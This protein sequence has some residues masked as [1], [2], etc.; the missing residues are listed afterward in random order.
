MPDREADPAHRRDRPAGPGK[1]TRRSRTDDQHLASSCDRGAAGST[2]SRRLNR[3]RADGAPDAEHP[4][5]HA[6][7]NR[8]NASPANDHRDTR[9]ERG[10]RVD[11]DAV[12]AL[13]Q[14]PA[15]VVGRRL[16]AEAE[17]RQP[18][19]AS[20]AP[21]APMVA[22]TTSGSAMLGRTC[23]TSSRNRPTPA[24]RAAATKSRSAIAGDQRLRQP[25]ERRRP[26]EPD[27]QHRALRA[28]PEDHREEER[29]Q[30]PGERDRDVHDRRRQPARA[31]PSSSRRGAEQQSGEDA[32]RGRQQGQRDRR[33]GSRPARGRRCPGRGCRCRASAGRRAFEQVVGV[34]RARPGRDQSRGAKHSEQ[35]YRE[36]QQARAGPDRGTQHGGPPRRGRAA[37]S[38]PGSSS[39][40]RAAARATS[41]A[42]F[43]S[44]TPTP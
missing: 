18:A 2:D 41:T 33:D 42:R 12:E 23:R 6:S 39:A 3:A 35:E 1:L 5:P 37:I 32:D 40:G 28:D 27:R 24:I 9:R 36:Q 21:P 26:G 16:H 22:L 11:V 7:P 19:K 13:A 44:S 31:R 30:Q 34:D 25:R 15:P 38:S 43:T 20:S 17:E 10:R 8:L 14:Q 29:E 4:S